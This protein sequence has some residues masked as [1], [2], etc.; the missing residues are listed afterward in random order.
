MHHE[1]NQENGLF[2]SI[3]TIFLFIVSLQS[4]EGWL[5]IMASIA[6]ICAAITTIYFTIKKNKNIK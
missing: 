4:V 2:G 5:R 6:T 3:V 1:P